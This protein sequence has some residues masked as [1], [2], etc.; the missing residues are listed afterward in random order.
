MWEFPKLA[1]LMEKPI[2]KKMHDE[3]SAG[4]IE[5]LIEIEVS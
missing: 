2:E 4:V 5:W 1:P 3:I